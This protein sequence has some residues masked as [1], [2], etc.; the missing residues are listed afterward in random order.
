[1]AR[2]NQGGEIPAANTA[3]KQHRVQRMLPARAHCLGKGF[4]FFFLNQGNWRDEACLIVE[5]K[6]CDCSCFLTQLIFKM[7]TPS[8][9]NLKD[10]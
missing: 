2:Y 1:M 9:I 6:N 8:T 5:T 7:N 10:R 4:F 3:P